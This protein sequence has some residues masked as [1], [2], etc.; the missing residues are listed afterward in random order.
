MAA[1]KTIGDKHLKWKISHPG[2]QHF[3]L[4]WFRQPAVGTNMYQVGFWGCG[5]LPR[6]INWL[7]ILYSTQRITFFTWGLKKL[8][9]KSSYILW[10]AAV[11]TWN[12]QAAFIRSVHSAVIYWAPIHPLFFPGTYASHEVYGGELNSRNLQSSVEN[13]HQTPKYTI[14]NCAKWQ[15]KNDRTGEGRGLWP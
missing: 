12:P 9:E 6:C 13:R 8:S 14:A 11:I 5:T 4:F 10:E 7:T 15:E 3:S 1:I 2:S